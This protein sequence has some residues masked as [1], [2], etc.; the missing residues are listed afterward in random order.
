MDIVN[1]QIAVGVRPCIIGVSATRRAGFNDTGH[2]DAGRAGSTGYGDAQF[3]PAI[4][5]YQ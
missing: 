1:I 3:L 4:I 2:A 5:P